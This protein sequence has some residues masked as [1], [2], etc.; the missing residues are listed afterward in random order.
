MSNQAKSWRD[1]AMSE[2]LRGFGN[3]KHGD[4]AIEAI[5][6]LAP[7][8][9]TYQ[10]WPLRQQA[11]LFLQG[12]CQNL[13]SCLAAESQFD[14]TDYDALF[15]A[16]FEFTW[17]GQPLEIVFLP[18]WERGEVLCLGE[19]IEA[20][21][22]FSK[23]LDAFTDR[24]LKRCLRFAAG[25]E[26]A[27]ELDEEIGKVTW[28]DIVLKAELLSGIRESVETFFAHK[29]VVQ[30]FGFAWK[31]GILL[32]GPPGTGKT[33]IC[34]AAA[35]ALPDLP[36]LYVRDLREND[37][38]E[39]IEAIFKRARKLAPCLLVM[40]DLD[41]LIN[42]ENRAIFLN[43]M[44]GFQSNDGILIIASSN[45]PGKID[46]AL[47]KRPSRFDRV[48]HIGLPEIAERRTFCE[49]LLTR[50]SLAEKLAPELDVV[51]LCDDVASKTEGFTPAYL[52]EA[53]VAAALSRAQQ[54]ATILDGEFA[55]AVL[56]QIKELRAHL[57]KAKNPDSLAE[58]RSGEDNIGFR[59]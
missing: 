12:Q 32:V 56:E 18:G 39:S 41:S 43:E 1:E 27:P 9:S 50:E 51:V 15:L 29:A 57:K 33:M 19:D 14:N 22:H 49:R 53:F 11:L 30:S 24:P 55:R 21:K 37:K 54:G 38:K 48:F 47:L 2:A 5:R 8:L 6:R 13:R 58:M 31:R 40:E 46:E 34:K 3:E 20:L 23:A 35:T 16:W 4:A 28:N 45:H 7:Q 17:Q 59:R 26:N 42:D 36:F 10:T 44:D 52:K 25:W